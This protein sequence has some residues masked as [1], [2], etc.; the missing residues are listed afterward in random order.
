M[1]PVQC[2][3][4]RTAL[5]LS[6]VGL[7]RQA[8]VSSNTVVRFERGEALKQR[9]IRQIQSA[10]ENAGIEFIPEAEGKGAGVRLAKPSGAHAD[11]TSD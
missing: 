7:S 4:A 3:M 2:R 8:G 10:L 5:N 11:G 9:T 1:I 6:V